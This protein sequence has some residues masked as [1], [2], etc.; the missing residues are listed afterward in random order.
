[1]AARIV[2]VC[3]GLWL[4]FSP[5]MVLGYDGPARVS[6][7][8]VGPLIATMATVAMS[9]VLRELRWVNLLLGAWLVVSVLFIPH[10]PMALVNGVAVG[11]A[12]TLLALVAGAHPNR[13]GGG[14][15]AVIRPENETTVSGGER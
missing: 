2:N 10:P 12:V 4:L 15:R 1:M 9:Q 6:H 7:L 3:L 11:L 13:L 14:W 8:I 5:D